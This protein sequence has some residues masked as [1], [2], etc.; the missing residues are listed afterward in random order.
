MSMKVILIRWVLLTRLCRHDFQSNNHSL[1]HLITLCIWATLNWLLT[2][3]LPTA[4]WWVITPPAGASGWRL[5]TWP[6]QKGCHSCI[7]M[8]PA[9]TH[10]H[11]ELMANSIQPHFKL[12]MHI[13]ILAAGQL[14]QFLRFTVIC[15]DLVYILVPQASVWK[16]NPSFYTNTFIIMSFWSFC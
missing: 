12:Q 5:I 4:S 6:W 16:C 10:T 14:M 2:A 7:N 3:R 1:C 8:W 13:H 11:S 9:W 15:T